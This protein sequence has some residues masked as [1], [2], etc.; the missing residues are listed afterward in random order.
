MACQEKRKDQKCGQHFRYNAA[1]CGFDAMS[2]EGL[3]FI[4]VVKRHAVNPEKFRRAAQDPWQ[5]KSAK[6]RTKI[7]P[8]ASPRHLTNEEIE[9]IKIE[10]V[11][12]LLR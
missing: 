12:L 1:Y 9:V 7:R 6:L 10:D 11:A 5:A 8:G 3:R 2:H 4:G